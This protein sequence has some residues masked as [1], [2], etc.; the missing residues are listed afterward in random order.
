MQ[1]SDIQ[2]GI[3]DGLS[4]MA[5]F[6]RLSK[7]WAGRGANRPCYMCAHLIEPSQVEYEIESDVAA[8]PVAR[9]FHSKC[10]DSWLELPTRE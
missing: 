3:V 6:V 1:I 4:A 5:A 10:Y 8:E 7:V 2:A 9:F